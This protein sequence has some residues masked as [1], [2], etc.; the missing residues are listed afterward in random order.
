MIYSLHCVPHVPEHLELVLSDEPFVDV[1]GANA[2]WR[3]PD[4]RFE[5]IQDQIRDLLASPAAAE[6]FG[7][8]DSSYLRSPASS[9]AYELWSTLILLGGC[10]AIHSGTRGDLVRELLG[11]QL[12]ATEQPPGRKPTNFSSWMPG[13]RP[14]GTVTVQLAGDDPERRRTAFALLQQ[15]VEVFAGIEPLE[16]RR[17]ALLSL[18]HLRTADPALRAADLTTP[19]DQLATTWRTQMP[20]AIAA[21]IP[22]LAG[23]AHYT[24]WL[25]DRLRTAD[26]RLREAVRPSWSPDGLLA[27][28]LRGADRDDVPDDL[29]TILGAER[30]DA[31]AAEL[32][33]LRTRDRH[34][35]LRD[36][37]GWLADTLVAGEVETARVWIDAA[38]RLMC[39]LRGWPG[40][41]RSGTTWLPVGGFLTDVR[42]YFTPRPLGIQLSAPPAPSVPLDP[43][44]G[45][46]PV[47]P[48]LTE[49]VAEERAFLMRRRAGLV[50]PTAPLRLAF[51]GNSGT[52]RSRA[53]TW[54]GTALHDIGTLARGHVVE[55]AANELAVGATTRKV[56]S[57]VREAKG[58]VLVVDDIHLLTPADST[59]DRQVLLE[60]IRQLTGAGSE[61]VAVIAGPARETR[62]ML[63]REP[64][65]AS[66]FTRRV[67]FPNYTRDH[68]MEIFAARAAD[69]GLSLE[70]G[71]LER[72]GAVIDNADAASAAENAR[73]VR[74]LLERSI[75]RQ[76]QRL[77]E[78]GED[79]DPEALAV[80]VADDVP[81]KFAAHLDRHSNRDPV[82]ALQRLIGLE[83]VKNE[84]Q[85]LV[86]EARA[87]KLRRDADIPY[88]GPSRHMIFTGSPGTAKTTVARLIGEIYAKLGLL[89]SGHL[90][91]TTRAD[92]VAGYI[93]QTAP[94]VQAA[95]ESALGGVLFIDEAYALVPA[96]SA[97]DFGHEA[98]ATLVALMENYR[99][100]LIV[101]VAGYPAEM[102]RFVTS[103]SGLASRFPRS[104]H[105]PDYSDHD[106]VAIFSMLATDAGFVLAGDVADELRRRATNWERGP[107]FGNGRFVRNLLEHTIALQGRRIT[108][109]PAAPTAEEIRELRLEDLPPEGHLPKPT[110]HA[111]FY[112]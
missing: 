64:T 30:R 69:A 81:E 90:V 35:W 33:P 49:V 46:E 103:N 60:L 13:I 83:T 92:L 50:V 34:R 2:P 47:G 36:V 84:V 80:L 59:A 112:V 86:A 78:A 44:L 12:F 53:A 101:I 70:D 73:L 38:Y 24:A 20:V 6:F 27:H 22:E 62:A 54:L 97:R 93:G 88:S 94:K 16:T 23:V 40:L 43:V 85:L 61:L 100:D 31:V 99:D 17:H 19:A 26:Q 109:G 106:L 9:V 57:L 79:P 37:R 48:T 74:S 39:A 10:S 45:R 66:I 28:L 72:V 29:T 96:D 58:G 5:E 55:A 71:V 65:L 105:F 82:G 8:N 75:G 1:V 95:V 7:E 21:R 11:G 41:P 98:V 91:E 56:E 111:G 14:P 102:R 51:L 108:A 52:G 32:V 3:V 77:M 67:E 15:C 110:R 68:L 18:Y 104:L 76:G 4:G 89:S 63:T 42:A 87:Q 107:A 25:D